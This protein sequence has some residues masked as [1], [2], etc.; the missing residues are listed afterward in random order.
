MLHVQRELH[1]AAR[2]G[3]QAGESV[4]ADD[5][6]QARMDLQSHD[7]TVRLHRRRGRQPQNVC[8]ARNVYLISR[9]LILDRSR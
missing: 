5:T 1:R 7:D 4:V 8:D 6:V 2:G 9:I 3:C